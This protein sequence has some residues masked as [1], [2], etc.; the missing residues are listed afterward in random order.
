MI[1]EWHPSLLEIQLTRTDLSCEVRSRVRAALATSID[2]YERSE[3]D[4]LRTGRPSSLPGWRAWQSIA[5]DTPQSRN[6]FLELWIFHSDSIRMIE[7]S[8]A[9]YLL[10]CM[11]AYSEQSGGL[12]EIGL[13]L[14]CAGCLRGKELSSSQVIR[15]RRL[16]A[17]HWPY[18]TGY[19]QT[20]RRDLREWTRV[21]F[22]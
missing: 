18:A 5:G 9:P 22:K 3:V 21:N 10:G 4:S 20:L 19:A 15:A 14:I 6:A 11:Q 1:S 13:S 2:N 8:P 7:K 12:K 17:S 16:S